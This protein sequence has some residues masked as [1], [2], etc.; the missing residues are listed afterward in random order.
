MFRFNAYLQATTHVIVLVL[1]ESTTALYPRP[2]LLNTT[3]NASK[4]ADPSLGV[5]FNGGYV[6]AVLPPSNVGTRRHPVMYGVPTGDSVR[7]CSVWYRQTRGAPE[8]LWG[9]IFSW[10][11]AKAHQR[12][13]LSADGEG[14][15]HFA[16]ESDDSPKVGGA[17]S[18][19]RHATLVWDGQHV[20]G[21]GE[22]FDP[23]TNK[24]QYCFILDETLQP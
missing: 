24:R 3:L 12:F 15:V 18:G 23:S 19:W 1:T 6:E 7:S 16:G 20:P 11:D 13:S 14:M 8:A 2:S 10:G 17:S 9:N 22:P 5:S 21:W 4:S